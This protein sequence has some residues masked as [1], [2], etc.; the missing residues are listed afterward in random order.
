MEA[1]AD[2]MPTTRTEFRPGEPIEIR[3]G[4][5]VLADLAALHDLEGD[6]L[7]REIEFETLAFGDAVKELSEALE[8]TRPDREANVVEVAY[9][10]TDRILVRDVPNAVARSF[11]AQRGEVQKTEVRSTV[12]FLQEQSEQLRSQLEAAEEELRAFREGR[13]IVALG[14]EAEAQVQRLAE[15]QTQRSQL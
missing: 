15:L 11:I 4:S 1:R 3:G 9:E 13:Q 12:G 8:V 10:G 5:F 14:A 2:E 6:A 7:P